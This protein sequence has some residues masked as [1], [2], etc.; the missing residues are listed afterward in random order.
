MNPLVN[1]QQS[2]VSTGRSR[3][4]VRWKRLVFQRLERDETEFQMPQ[5]VGAFFLLRYDRRNLA[6][7]LVL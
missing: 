5:S 2:V 3:D 7:R 1:F 4:L 6:G